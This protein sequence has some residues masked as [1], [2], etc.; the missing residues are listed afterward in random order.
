MDADVLIAG[1]EPTGLLLAGDL[2]EA[3]VAVT[4]L[5][6]RAEES[7]VTRA[8][9]V[10][11][12][13]MEEL[14]IRGVAGQLARTGTQIRALRL[15]DRVNIDLSRLPSEFNSL[16]ITPQF[17]TER[18]LQDRADALGVRIV[19]GA[20]VTGVTQDDH[21]VDVTTRTASY[22]ASYAV[23]ADGVKSA[24]RT[25]L[26]LP[27]PGHSVIKS[28]MLAD[29]RLSSPPGDVLAVNGVGDGFAFVAP[30]GDGWYRV[31]AW[32]R[33]NQVG[34]SAPLDLE[35]I[36]EVTRRALSTDFGM[37]DP[38]WLSRFHSDERQVPRYRVG[39]VFL[40]GDA[41][42]CHSPAGGMGMNTGMQDAANLGWKLAAAIHGWGDEQLLDSYHE[43]RHRV[44]RQVLR[45]SGAL[46]RLALI[47]PQW[48]QRAR[49]AIGH[50]LTA[51]PP[52]AA[53][54]AGTISGVGIRYPA[55]PGTDRRVGTRVPNI[56]LRGGRLYEA[57]RG[58]R[59]VLLGTG[60]E[61]VERLLKST[62]LC[63]RDPSERSRSS[64]PMATWPGWERRIG[65]P[66]GRASTSP[67]GTDRAPAQS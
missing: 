3:G 10:H 62:P 35:E 9:A 59:F 24:V 33:R 12:R 54:V 57:L 60:A 32:N 7:N 28:I 11:A 16:L 55:P 14:Q 19:R 8:F 27:Y 45:S 53:T 13:T 25:A 56:A 58:G 26:G 17:Q 43:E 44:G 61:N 30:F 1:A 67:S 36:R 41:A 31:F 38:R 37:H 18:V 21:G 65:S 23:G 34:D 49:G 20:E 6:R 29:V 15:F 48:A 50:A 51:V 47:R 64:G 2:A 40:A 46:I 63:Q 39:R 4:V 5:E 42:H 66:P 52:I 22:R